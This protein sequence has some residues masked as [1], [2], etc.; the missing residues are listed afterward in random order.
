MEKKYNMDNRKIDSD[1]ILKI[2]SERKER[3][4]NDLELAMKFIQTDF[5]YTK[6]NLLKMSNHLDKLENT[7][8]VLLKEYKSRKGD[9]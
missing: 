3:S 6:E 5:D 2:I 8:N 4:N 7:Y 9:R 1:E